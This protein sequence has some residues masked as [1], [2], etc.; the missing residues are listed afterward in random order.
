VTEIPNPGLSGWNNFFASRSR[1]LLIAIHN[2]WDTVTY[3]V[4]ADPEAV[5]TGGSKE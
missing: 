4:V 3:I 1:F 2:A 5:E